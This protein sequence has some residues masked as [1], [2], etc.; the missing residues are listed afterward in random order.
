[1]NPLRQANAGH[2]NVQGDYHPLDHVGKRK[3]EYRKTKIEK[4]ERKK[5]VNGEC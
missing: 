5:K 4:A 1:M 2:Q 3:E